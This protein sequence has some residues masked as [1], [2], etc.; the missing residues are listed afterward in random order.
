MGFYIETPY[1]KGK[2]LQIIS[3]YGGEE[4]DEPLIFDVPEGKGL[5]CVVDNGEFEAAGF[6]YNLNE[7]LRFKHP[8]GR[9]KRWVIID[10]KVAEHVTGYKEVI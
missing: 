6:A 2:V 8:D 1:N 9:P 3:K 10:R 7:F 5:I 4:V